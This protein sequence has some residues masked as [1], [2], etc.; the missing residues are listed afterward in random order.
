[1]GLV[2]ATAV[3]FG[4]G[5]I[6]RGFVAPCLRQ[7]GYEVVLSDLLP[8]RTD[9]SYQGGKWCAVLALARWVDGKPQATAL[10]RTSMHADRIAWL[11]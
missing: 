10:A 3:H 1:M 4:A 5:N 7:S 11:V 2:T 6:G 8:N 9:L